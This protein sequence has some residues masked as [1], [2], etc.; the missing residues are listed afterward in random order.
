MTKSAP[1]ALSRSAI[2]SQ[3][4]MSSTAPKCGT[5]TSWPSTGL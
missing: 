5:G 1:A 3:A 4:A 2:A